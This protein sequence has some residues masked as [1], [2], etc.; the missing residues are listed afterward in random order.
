VRTSSIASPDCHRIGEDLRS[1]SHKKRVDLKLPDYDGEYDAT[2]FVKHVN[3]ISK[4]CQWDREEKTAHV[5]VAL[6][7]KARK[8]LSCL[9][10]DSSM[11]A[12]IILSALVANFGER[13]FKDVARSKLL[14]RKQ[15][16]NETY[17]QLALEVEK[18]VNHAY[19]GVDHETKETLATEAFL[20]AL[21]DP[22]VK[23]QLRL[24]APETLQKAAH[25][26]ES[27][28]ACLRQA[29]GNRLKP[30]LL[31]SID[32]GNTKL[33]QSKSLSAEKD[34]SL[35]NSVKDCET[36]SQCSAMHHQERP[37]WQRKGNYSPPHLWHNRED[38][39]CYKCGEIGHVAKYCRVKSPQINQLLNFRSN[40]SRLEY[41]QGNGR[42][43]GTGD[44]AN[45]GH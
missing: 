33:Q 28:E 39:K 6:K 17:S 14:D 31:A 38:P 30:S 27:V 18:L 40:G 25:Q 23:L 20:N 37:P 19:P 45:L 43:S 24:H 22:D 29:R 4:Y 13:L 26:A 34:L 32:T 2:L 9:S 41:K 1:Q 10:S 7:G 16:R 42:P 15:N 11:D 5:I 35:T 21:W 8:I 3:R 36:E 12:E 44:N